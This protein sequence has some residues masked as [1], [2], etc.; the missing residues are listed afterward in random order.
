[1]KRVWFCAQQAHVPS[2]RTWEGCPEPHFSQPTATTSTLPTLLPSLDDAAVAAMTHADWH[3]RLGGACVARAVLCA[4]PA[5]EAGDL[6]VLPAAVALLSDPEPRVRLAAGDVLGGLAARDVEA[7]W[8]VAGPALTTV[9]GRDWDRDG[10]PPPRDGGPV[11]PACGDGA[12][13]HFADGLVGDTLAAAYAAPVPGVGELRHGSEGWRCLETAFR[14]LLAIMD[15]AGAAFA[16]YATP[17]LRGTVTKALLHPNR[18][19][20]ESAYSALGGL[21]S[22]AAADGTLTDW[23]DAAAIALADG[24]SENWSQVRLAACVAARALL[25]SAASVN[26]DLHAPPADR[27]AAPPRLQPAGRGGR[28][29]RLQRGHVGAGNARARRGR[30]GGQH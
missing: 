15:G 11:T 4:R 29:G 16:P 5:G 22:L 2:K 20:R 7:T 3:V 23:G 17:E 30:G 9:V 25:T 10:A 27:P 18:Y 1:M 28:G 6:R 19:V 24:L 12:S 21:A 14:A 8:A 13:P 26:P